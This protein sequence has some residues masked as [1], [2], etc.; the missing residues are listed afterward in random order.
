MIA[1]HR[2]FYAVICAFNASLAGFYPCHLCMSRQGPAVSTKYM[3]IC[4]QKS[5][6]STSEIRQKELQI[7][8]LLEMPRAL[9]RKY[10]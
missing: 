2:S 9:M 3:V 1:S 6:P 5:T 4:S 8:F 7:I 10:V